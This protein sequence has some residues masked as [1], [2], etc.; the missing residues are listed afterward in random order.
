LGSSD[1][2]QDLSALLADL[3]HA[4]EEEDALP[5]AA[6]KPP[7]AAPVNVKVADWAAGDFDTD[8][9]NPPVPKPVPAPAPR[10]PPAVPVSTPVGLDDAFIKWLP[11]GADGEGEEED[12][13]APA[14]RKSSGGP[15]PVKISLPDDFDDDDDFPVQPAS[16]AASG[17]GKAAAPAAPAARKSSGDSKRVRISLS[18]DFDDD[19]DDGVPVQ[20]AHVGQSASPGTALTATFKTMSDA[21]QFTLQFEPK[22]IVKTAKTRVAEHLGLDGP[23]SVNLYPDGRV[24]PSPFPSGLWLSKVCARNPL[25]LVE[26]KA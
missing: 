24:S 9:D 4:N 22:A 23:D 15:A 11:G 7:G 12:L 1:D 25:I 19:D 16:V 18:D 3:K 14:P 17:S 8:E 2:D 20:P 6:A 5:A 13:P 10:P 21:G 26:I